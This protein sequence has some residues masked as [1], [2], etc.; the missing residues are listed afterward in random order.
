MKNERLFDALGGVSSDYVTEAATA[1]IPAAKRRPRRFHKGMIAVAAA[2]IALITMTI[3]LTISAEEEP[4][5]EEVPVIMLKEDFE[6]LIVAELEK[7]VERNEHSETWYRAERTKAFYE[8][9]DLSLCRTEKGKT[10]LL[11]R[12][13]ITEFCVVYALDATATD[14]EKEFI[15]GQLRSIGFSQIDLIEAYENL[16][17]AVEE[18]DS[19]NK[20]KI[21]ATLPEIPP[22][23]V[24]EGERADAE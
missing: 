7:Q 9:W 23:P 6:R 21:L 12:F 3:G 24:S 15:L 5:L 4:A 11:E 13:P 8:Y 20:E 16:Y 19:P 22:R 1:N 14:V 17:R 18:S 2:M 10:V